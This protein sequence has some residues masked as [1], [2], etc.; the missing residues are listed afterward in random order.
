MYKFLAATMILMT[1]SLSSFAEDKKLTSAQFLEKVRR[2]KF[3]DSWARMKGT[4]YHK[5]NKITDK[6][7]KVKQKRRDAEVPVYLA[8]RFAKSAVVGQLLFNKS[9]LYSIGQNF[10]EKD[11]NL[12]STTVQI[13]AAKK[14]EDSLKDFGLRASDMTMSFLYWKF[15]SEEKED[16]ISLED[17]RVMFLKSSSGER[18]K[19]WLAVKYFFPLKV[20]WY[21]KDAK[22]SYR[23][24]EFD[25][26]KKIND[27]TWTIKSFQIKNP[28]WK[29]TVDFDK[30]IEIEKKSVKKEPKDLFKQVSMN[31]DEDEEEAVEEKPAK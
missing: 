22:K 23:T 28:G 26:V 16:S 2:P 3:V 13:Q 11:V 12:S 19:V 21:K 18:V 5:R 9:E 17:C 20:E 24:V 30:S 10:K 8:M 31:L 27:T 15:E 7:G 25:E 1:F 6:N 14:G 29:T 4:A